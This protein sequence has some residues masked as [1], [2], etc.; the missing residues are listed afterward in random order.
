MMTNDPCFSP[1]R[2][3]ASVFV[4]TVCNEK[5]EK[6]LFEFTPIDTN[7]YKALGNAIWFIHMPNKK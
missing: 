3:H 6:I 7:I 5:F 4:G 1:Q 2:R